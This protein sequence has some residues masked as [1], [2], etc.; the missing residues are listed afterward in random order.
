MR[1]PVAAPTRAVGLRAAG[2]ACVVAVRRPVSIAR[3]A[4]LLHALAVLVACGGSGDADIEAPWVGS[5]T[6]EDGITT[7]HNESGS[8]WGGTATLVEETSIGVDAGPS[9]L[10]FG[11]VASVYEHDGTIYVVDPQV[12]AVRTFDLEGNYLATLGAVGQGPGEYT[13]PH[14]VAIAPDGRIFVSEP[15]NDRIN[16][17]A[18]DGTSLDTWT[19]QMSE[20]LTSALV[21]DESGLLWVPVLSRDLVP[22]GARQGIRAMPDGVPGEYAV[23]DEL[24]GQPV[25]G[26]EGDQP[27]A[28][29]AA[30][31]GTLIVGWA[32]ALVYHF[33]IQHRGEPV[34]RIERAWKPTPLDP[35]FAAWYLA[36][37]GRERP[38][39]YPAYIGFTKA[40]SGEIWVTRPGPA[41]YIEGCHDDLSDLD[42][43]R[44]SPCWRPAFIVDAFGEDGRYLGAVAMPHDVTPVVQWMHID[45]DMVVARSVGDDGVTR[46]KRYRLLLPG[47]GG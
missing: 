1:S 29:T 14:R 13:E 27:I 18:A 34:L 36:V 3:A 12:P 15:G 9:E 31:G 20:S 10:M 46:V 21:F 42:A 35:D 19:V 32:N 17:Y 5:T 23:I 38:A 6:T 26:P 37:Y 40:A 24:E 11:N 43:A 16:V 25:E 33:E 30:G 22:G 39:T 4:I 28:W 47:G 2:E 8:V 45:G 7:V 41:R 44:A